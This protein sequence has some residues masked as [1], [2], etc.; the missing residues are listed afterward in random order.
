MRAAGYGPS[1]THSAEHA[2]AAFRLGPEALSIVSAAQYANWPRR[3]SHV[4]D[5]SAQAAPQPRDIDSDPPRLIFR[6]HVRLPRLGLGL[7]AVEVGDRLSTGVT[8]DWPPG[9]VSACHGAGK[10]AGRVGSDMGSRALLSAL[11]RGFNSKPF[12]PHLH[13]YDIPP[14]SVGC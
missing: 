8:D 5:R 6:E 7:A 2:A 14:P 1:L 11:Y 12:A 3:L 10:A 13:Q 9:I 4:G